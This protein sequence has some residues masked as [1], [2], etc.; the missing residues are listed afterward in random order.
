[1]EFLSSI[2]ITIQ[3]NY[4]VIFLYNIILQMDEDKTKLLQFDKTFRPDIL[5]EI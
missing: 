4:K 2:Y 1:M 3:R 5:N